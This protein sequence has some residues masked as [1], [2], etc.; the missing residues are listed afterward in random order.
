MSAGGAASGARPAAAPAAGPGPA[1]AGIR[2]VVT[3][4]SSGL[5]RAM[6]Q[7][8][9]QA[10]AEVMAAARSGPRLDA[11]V[12]AWRDR[13][14]AATALPVDVRDPASVEAAATHVAGTWGA[15]D[16]LVNNAGIGMRTVNPAS[17]SSRAAAGGSCASR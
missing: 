4:A 16:L 3:G 9:L 10:G 12:A 7:A 5:G 8:L 14:L 1:L 11:A 17:C 2:A 6:A 13:G 15:P